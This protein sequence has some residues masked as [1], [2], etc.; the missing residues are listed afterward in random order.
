MLQ[1]WIKWR[2]VRFVQ[3]GDCDTWQYV[4]LYRL[5]S[6]VCY[7]KRFA[8]PTPLWLQGLKVLSLCPPS[9]PVSLQF[10]SA[11]TC[12][13]QLVNDIL[14][15]QAHSPGML[16]CNVNA[17]FVLSWDRSYKKKKKNHCCLDNSPELQNP[18]LQ[19][20]CSVLGF[21]KPSTSCI[22]Y[23]IWSLCMSRQYMKQHAPTCFQS[24][25]LMIRTFCTNIHR[26]LQ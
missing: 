7:A 17:L 19:T 18:V 4:E 12:W 2:Y 10:L 14:Y 13:L 26:L 25:R 8:D 1:T 6:S 22:C 21:D 16:L 5:F 23:S 20:L 11:L 24:K 3:L 15:V 9:L